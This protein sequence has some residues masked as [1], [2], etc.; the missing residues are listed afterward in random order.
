MLM[1]AVAICIVALALPP[2]ALYVVAAEAFRGLHDYAAASLQG[3]A[4]YVAL[5]TVLFGA[6]YLA[7]GRVPLAA[8]AGACLTA[9]S[10]ASGVAI[11]S[12]MR[13]LR[14]LGPLTHVDNRELLPVALPL[15]A[16]YLAMLVA[17]Q[18]DLWVLGAYRPA[19][20]VAAYAAAIRLV[21]HVCAPLLIMGAVIAPVIAELR[22]AGDRTALERVVQRAALVDLVPALVAFVALLVAAGDILALLFGE[23]YRLGATAALLLGAGLLGQALMGPALIV[24]AMSTG[25]R[26]VMAVCMVAGMVQVTGGLL[27]VEHL[28]MAGVAAVSA[29]SATLQALLAMLLV[30]WQ[31]GMWTTPFVAGISAVA[32][33]RQTEG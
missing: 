6:F 24:L 27:V 15:M 12:L 14:A 4:L 13:R 29:A 28:G 10:I 11:V 5:L 20:E 16:G 7:E 19:A 21:Q 25:Q 32:A 1:P 3:P 33:I 31:S 18:A 22:L 2:I 8:A 9:A 26:A 17:S 30:R 23:H